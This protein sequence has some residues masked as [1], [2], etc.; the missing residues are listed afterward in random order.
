MR[1]DGAYRKEN[2]VKRRYVAYGMCAIVA[3][4]LAV[5]V[6]CNNSR[7]PVRGTV[8]FDGKTVEEGVISL[9]PAD[10]QG[11]TT[12]GKIVRGTYEL[13][14]DAAP[15]P[16]KKTV[17]IS[18]ARKTGRKIP[19]QFAPPGSMTDQLVR[20]IP[21]VYNTKTTLF[22]EVVENGPNQINFDLKTK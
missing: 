20:Y 2:P 10:G 5:L 12:G 15:L 18:A 19:A 4:A 22:C 6:G 7:T 14:G 8:T 13:A 16:G 1:L 9:E 3:T 17:R 11:P 21:D